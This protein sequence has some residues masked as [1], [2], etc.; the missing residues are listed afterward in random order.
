M[1]DFGT[2]FVSSTFSRVTN[3]LARDTI[4]ANLSRLQQALLQT[5]EEA[6]TGKRLTRTSVDPIASTIALNFRARI[7]RDGEFLRGLDAA[8]G[9]LAVTDQT[10]GQA[11]GIVER[12]RAIQLAQFQ[13]TAETRDAAAIEVDALLDGAIALANTRF[14]NHYLFAGSR[15]T[16]RPF[17]AVSG[18]VAYAGDADPT[19]FAL[20]D[21]GPDA[22]AVAGASVFGGLSD[23]IVGNADLD[24]DINAATKLSVL[25]GGRGVRAGAIAV[26]TTAATLRT[27]DLRIAE[28]VGDVINLIN[29]QTAA[30]GVTAALNVDGNGIDLASATT[31]LVQEV[32]GGRTALDLGLPNLSVPAAL[33]VNGGAL[34]PRLA[35]STPLS[36]LNG[37]LG[38]DLSGIVITQDA[39]GQTHTA[40]LGFAGLATVEDVLNRI[41]TSELFV[42]ARLN[43]AGTGIDLRSRLSGARLTVAENGGATAAHLGILTDNP[44]GVPTGAGA[45]IQIQTRDGTLVAVD[46]SAALTLQDVAAAVNAAAPP[47]TVT[48]T[49][50][51]LNRLVLTDASAGAALFQVTD[52]IPGV[53]TAGALGVLQSTANAVI[54]G[55]DPSPIRRARVADLNN[56]FGI[57]TV[58]GDDIQIRRRDGTAFEVDL[59]G[60]QTVQD[61]VDA[62][63]GDAQNGGTVLADVGFAGNLLLR[64][65]TGA[66]AAP[67]EARNFNESRT[68]TLL[69]IERIGTPTDIVGASLNW[70]GDQSEGLFTALVRLRDALRADS[71][72]GIDEAGRLLNLAQDRLLDARGEVGGRVARLEMTQRRFEDEQ[73]T[74]RDLLGAVEDADLADVATRL[75]L[76]TTTL[77]AALA[78]TA[79]LFESSLLNYL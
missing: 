2:P 17:G 54:L 8:G 18:A 75:Q 59:S 78:V 4:Q 16:V 43:E 50:D 15:Q 35:G 39:P 33:L 11:Q 48:A 66:A 36:L 29:A 42:E 73:D 60:A 12:A 45:D 37:G 1:T 49:I 68:A 14:E 72:A 27:I 65:L 24:P 30:T 32:D 53:P 76:Q 46:L 22:V 23:V 20:S 69:G 61:I 3:V 55:T 25:N 7:Q 70:A 51:A 74:L 44:L 71:A 40:A 19:R 9:R 79:R 47:G 21:A 67:F 34:D 41:N 62:I 10:L 57:P 58:E 28:D 52:L 38:L 64:D 77:Q 56:G 13:G 5:Q 31:V 6:A 63:N 26:G